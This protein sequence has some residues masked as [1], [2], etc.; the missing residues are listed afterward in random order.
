MGAFGIPTRGVA[1]QP[2]P[3][4]IDAF[5]STNWPRQRCGTERPWRDF[6]GWGGVCW[7]CGSVERA[8]RCAGRNFRRDCDGCCTLRMHSAHVARR[9]PL[10][11]A[12]DPR[13]ANAHHAYGD[14][15]TVMRV[16][17]WNL[18][19]WKPGHYKTLENR[20]RQW[21]HLLALNP[22]VVLLQECRP[23][24]FTRYVTESGRNGYSVVGTIPAGWTACSAVMARS[25]FEAEA[26]STPHPWFD[27]LGGYVCRARIRL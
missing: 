21:A 9:N 17:S 12:Q 3:P 19:Y 1:S 7:L 25:G 10:R 14:G 15:D 6:V 26:D 16:V 23:G 4:R 5:G 18:A 24:D 22:D 20:R 8:R 27:A 2:S 13:T 11:P